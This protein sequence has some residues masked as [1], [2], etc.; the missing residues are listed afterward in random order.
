MS[1]DVFRRK[2]FGIDV[3]GLLVEVEGNR[4]KEFL[5]N[6]IN[7]RSEGRRG[8]SG[9]MRFNCCRIAYICM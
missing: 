7:E 8:A 6:G 1:D 9:P 5:E 3:G 4:I 2:A